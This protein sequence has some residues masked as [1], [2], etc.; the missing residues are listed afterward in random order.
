MDHPYNREGEPIISRL[1]HPKNSSQEDKRE[2]TSGS[3]PSPFAFGMSRYGSDARVN[4]DG[5]L[6]NVLSDSQTLA[7]GP[8][9]PDIFFKYQKPSNWTSTGLP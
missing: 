7:C 6:R 9:R 4:Q 3:R 8:S 5:L 1:V 2:S